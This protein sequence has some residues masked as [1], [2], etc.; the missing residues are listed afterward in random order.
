MGVS[1]SLVKNMTNKES[2]PSGI[3]A[4]RDFEIESGLPVPRNRFEKLVDKLDGC[5]GRKDK[6]ARCQRCPYLAEC[7]ASF[8]AICG[9]VAMY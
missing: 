4:L 5:A 8:D 6:T 3:Q 9:K 7:I 2:L 1:L